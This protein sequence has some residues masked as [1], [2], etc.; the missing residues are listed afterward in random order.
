MTRTK[1]LLRSLTGTLAIRIIIRTIQYKT[2]HL[3]LQ[4]YESF[5]RNLEQDLSSAQAAEGD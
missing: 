1:P 5:I 3:P 2:F 4:I